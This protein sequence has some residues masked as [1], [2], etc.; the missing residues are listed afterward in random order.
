[1]AIVG[2]GKLGGREMTATSDLDLIFIYGTPPE[3]VSSVGSRPL[4]ATQ[5]FARLSQRLINALTAP[6]AEGRLYEVDMRLRPSGK[7]GP[8]A[9]SLEGFERYQLEEAWTW[10]Q[11]AL[12]RA[13]VIVGPSM[14]VNQI[15]NAIN[16]V[17]TSRRNGEDLVVAV[18]EMR[19]RMESEHHTDSIWDVKYLRGGL[20]DI[21][22]IAQY[23]QLLHAHAQPQVLSVNTSAALRGIRD[24]QVLEPLVVD[25]LIDGLTLWQRV[26]ERLRLTLSETVD[27][28]GEDDAPVALRAALRDVAGLEF[29]QLV[30]KMRNTAERVHG[31]FVRIVDEPAEA[32]APRRQSESS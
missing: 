26:Q 27:A 21:E 15:E 22:F 18:S 3:S 10:E 13:R 17:L 23:L 28:A 20:V 32:L 2:M 1:M 8:I 16:K 11:M 14:L 4:P 9:T 12:T 6:T 25:Q 19:A 5:Y 29:D 31:H 7:A 24:A 30:D